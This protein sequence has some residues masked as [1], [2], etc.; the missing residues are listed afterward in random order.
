MKKFYL[1]LTVLAVATVGLS[2][3]TTPAAA[4]SG[5]KVLSTK[6]VKKTAY[7]ATKGTIYKTNK[8]TKVAHHAKNYKYTTLYVTKQSTVR[9]ANH[10]KAVYSYITT[11]KARG[12]I[13]RSYLKKGVAPK[14]STKTIQTTTTTTTTA[15]KNDDST[16][17]QT[18]AATFNAQAANA[19][20]L[21]MVNKERAKTGAA[22]LTIATKLT[23]LANQ[24]AADCAKLGDITHYDSAGNTV[25]L[26][27]GPKF[28]I[29]FDEG[30]SSECLYMADEGFVGDYQKAGTN[31]AD[32]YLYHDAESN[33]GHRDNLI[34]PEAKT[35]GIGW[36]ISN[37]MI[38]NAVDQQG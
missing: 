19:D 38:Y 36:K 20:F 31:A 34:N 3:T 28:G 12:W 18:T 14:K 37:G 6:K 13:L 16:T 25:Y 35:I 10:K 8:L 26:E 4:K 5:A 21:A 15:K 27:E 23:N 33:W 22:P 2:A 1:A 9:K 29:N 30:L 7:H 24:R 11:K 32:Q 17:T